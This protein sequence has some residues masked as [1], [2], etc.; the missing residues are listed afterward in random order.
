M[1]VQKSLSSKYFIMS[2]LELKGSILELIASIDDPTSLH[3][4][5][6]IISDFVGNRI[7]DSD[8]W[9]ELT[10]QEKEALELAIEESEEEANHVTHE[11]VMKKYSKWLGK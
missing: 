1:D 6:K 7:K 10:E 9:E 2:K 8:Y 4:L 5:K 11:E 3:E